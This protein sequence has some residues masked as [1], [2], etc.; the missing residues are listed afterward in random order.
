MRRRAPRPVDGRISKQRPSPE[1]SSGERAPGGHAGVPQQRRNQRGR[2]RRSGSTGVAGGRRTAR[3][4]QECKNNDGNQFI[5]RIQG[6][7]PPQRGR[8]WRGMSEIR[9]SP[10]ERAMQAISRFET[11]YLF[12]SIRGALSRQTDRTTAGNAAKAKSAEVTSRKQSRTSSKATSAL[13]D[14]SRA[15]GKTDTTFCQAALLEP[16]DDRW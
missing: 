16:S 8:V 7:I 5:S 6:A 12:D 2:R 13:V 1:A 3:R 14:V 9:P 4:H 11:T 10:D 15:A